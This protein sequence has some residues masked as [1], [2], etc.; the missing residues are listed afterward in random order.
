M[1]TLLTTWGEFLHPDHVLEEYPRPQMVRESYLNLNGFWD[2]AIT[3][4]WEFPCRMDGTILVPFSPE[5]LLSRVHR[6]LQPDE[7]LW[8]ER[9]LPVKTPKDDSRC[10]L[11]FGAVDQCAIEMCIRDRVL[12]LCI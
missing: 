5:T 4:E 6:K 8:Y 12:F 11:H 2:Y 9:D 10:I 1:N 7:Y 3:E